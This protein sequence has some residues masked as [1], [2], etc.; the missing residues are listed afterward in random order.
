[1]LPNQVIPFPN[2]AK[3]IELVDAY[4]DVI[5]DAYNSTRR[6]NQVTAKTMVGFL[7]AAVLAFR[8]QNDEY[9]ANRF[10]QAGNTIDANWETYATVLIKLHHDIRNR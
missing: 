1:M 9:W 8:H 7:A 3:K 10:Q 5:V 6:F 4:L 2:P